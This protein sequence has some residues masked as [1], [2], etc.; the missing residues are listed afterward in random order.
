MIKNFL[1]LISLIAASIFIVSCSESPTD[2]SENK[3]KNMVH[4]AFAGNIKTVRSVISNQEKEMTL[5]GKIISDPDKTI[6]YV[7]LINGIIE[8]TYFSLGDRVKKGQV[9]MDIRSTELSSLHSERITLEAEMRIAER[10]LRTI[11]EMYEDKMSS[12][13]DL[14]EAENKL[15]QIRTSLSKIQNDMAVFGTNKGDG[16]FSINAPMNGYIIKKN[17]SSGSTISTDSEPLFSIADLSSVWVIVNVYASQL[18][19]VREGMD[20]DISTLSYPDKTFTGKISNISQVFDSE[21][22]ALKARII[23]PNTDMKLKSEMS[24]VVKLKDMTQEGL[25]TIPSDAVIFDDNAYFVV[26]D[27]GNNIYEKQEIILYDRNKN[28]TYIKSGLGTDENVV[29]K[30]QLLIYSELKEK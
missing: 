25:V 12:E 28:T 26:V 29:I 9:L 13:K 23:L 2:Q 6:N 22:K 8:R 27:K 30:N 14:L 21:D 19:F 10:E 16:T 24:V 17:A 5:T 20:A 11:K 4:K 3:D 18:Q 15:Q 1:P 7:P